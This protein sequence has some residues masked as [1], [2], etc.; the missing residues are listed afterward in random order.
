LMTGK[1]PIIQD[2]LLDIIRTLRQPAGDDPRFD[3]PESIRDHPVDFIAAVHSS[4]K[5]I[6]NRSL[7]ELLKIDTILRSPEIR[8]YPPDLSS[9][10]R[11]SMAL[12]RR[13]ND[14]LVWTVLG[15]ED[16]HI[17]RLCHRKD[18]PS[19]LHANP[20]ALRRLLDDINRDPM[21]FALWTDATSCVDVGDVIS[22]RFARGLL[23]SLD[24]LEVKEGHVN[25][26]IMDLMRSSDDL[27][28]RVQQIGAFRSPGDRRP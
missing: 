13:V 21:T 6:H 8:T 3:T 24:I 17:R 14:A 19:L 18:R 9:F 7:D 25:G 4:W 15:H 26:R 1:V 20:R 27:E 2:E 10:L 22:R 11:Y 5:H 16:H 23:T 12:W 28:S